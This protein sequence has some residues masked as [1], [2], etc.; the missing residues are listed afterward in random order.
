MRT[1]RKERKILRLCTGS[2]LTNEDERKRRKRKEG[3]TGRMLRLCAE[4]RR[5]E[6]NRRM[7]RKRAKKEIKTVCL[8]ET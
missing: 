6:E 3:R 1:R 7:R 4:V 8:T 2:K 5:A